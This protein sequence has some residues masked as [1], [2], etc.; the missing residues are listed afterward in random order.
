MV[1]A[2]QV[3]PIPVASGERQDA[4]PDLRRSTG[5]QAHGKAER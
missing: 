4:L 3:E 1:K 5:G 2:A